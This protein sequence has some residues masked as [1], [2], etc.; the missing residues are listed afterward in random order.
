MEAERFDC[1]SIK[2][3]N[4]KDSKLAQKGVMPKAM[5]EKIFS[6]YT[7][8]SCTN[9]IQCS[10]IVIKTYESPVSNI[11]LCNLTKLRKWQNK[12]TV[13]FFEVGSSSHLNL[14]W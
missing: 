3:K 6:T 4:Q 12:Y 5:D 13:Q 14:Y 10:Y 8:W 2:K 9:N 7:L 11:Q 1:V